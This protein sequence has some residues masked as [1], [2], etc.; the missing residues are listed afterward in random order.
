MTNLW[1]QW[2]KKI[3]K[4]TNTNHRISISFVWLEEFVMEFPRVIISV[5]QL[6]LLQLFSGVISISVMNLKKQLKI[7][8]LLTAQTIFIIPFVFNSI[9]WKKEKKFYEHHH[10]QKKTN[11]ESKHNYGKEI[12]IRRNA[13]ANIV[14]FVYIC[15]IK[16]K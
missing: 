6:Q 15:E 1:V 16:F 4:N 12:S 14:I 7:L 9:D 13:M 10:H 8:F 3:P 2:N 5:F 11:I